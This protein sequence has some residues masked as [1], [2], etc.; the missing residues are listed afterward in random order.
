MIMQIR[1]SFEGC[2][3]PS[4]IKSRV[5]FLHG[6]GSDGLDL[7]SIAQQWQ[8]ALP[9]TAFYAPNAPIPCGMGFAWYDL[10]SHDPIHLMRGVESVS[11]ALRHYL[12]TFESPLPSVFVGFSQGASLAIH[13]AVQGFPTVKGAVSYSGYFA[14]SKPQQLTAVAPILLVHGSQDSVV[15]LSSFQNAFETLLRFEAPVEAALRPGLEHTLDSEG[16]SIGLDF[17]KRHLLP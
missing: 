15:P 5:I 7:L 6:F 16:L 17:I 9:Y 3:E 12:A 2:W 1:H 10:S 14:S 11:G 13:A 4:T 8:S